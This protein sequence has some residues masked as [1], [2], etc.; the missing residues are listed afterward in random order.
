MLRWDSTK[1]F[2][3]LS[4]I[5]MKFTLRFILLTIFFFVASKPADAQLL[6]DAASLKLIQKGL[7]HIY[8]Y[9]YAEANV[10]LNQV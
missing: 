7:D 6:N 4:M 3:L 8:N 9:E 1:P 10:I 5:V 2:I